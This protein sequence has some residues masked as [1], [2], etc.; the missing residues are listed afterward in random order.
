MSNISNGI[1]E[2]VRKDNKGLMIN[3]NWYSSYNGFSGVSKGDVV[4]FSFKEKG[5]W[6]NIN[7][8][9][10]KVSG[11]TVGTT[12]SASTSAPQAPAQD[13]PPHYMIARGYMNKVQTFPV[14]YDHP[15]RAIIRQNSLTNAVNMIN[16]MGI[17]GGAPNDIAEV[18]LE[19]ASI[20]EQ[21]STGQLEMEEAEKL[22]AAMA[23]TESTSD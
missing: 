18:V 22:V 6:K 5:Q 17:D 14:A 21:Y 11:G 23:H 3:G 4:S 10:E 15:D 20:F 7:G 9:I 1:V 2:A 19:I 12:D 13:L 16:G 8:A